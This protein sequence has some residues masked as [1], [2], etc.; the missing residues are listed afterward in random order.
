MPE[1]LVDAWKVEQGED[2]TGDPAIWGCAYYALF[3]LLIAA[4]GR[5]VLSGSELWGRLERAGLNQMRFT[6]AL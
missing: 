6:A 1:C 5:F 2:A 4:S 3:H